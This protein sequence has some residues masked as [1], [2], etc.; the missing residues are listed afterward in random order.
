[1]KRLLLGSLLSCLVVGQISCYPDIWDCVRGKYREMVQYFFKPKDSKAFHSG[2]VEGVK[3]ASLGGA[4]SCVA[5]GVYA[6]EMEH[7][8]VFNITRRN[9]RLAVGALAAGSLYKGYLMSQVDRNGQ[10]HRYFDYYYD[11]SEVPTSLGQD[12]LN[13]T[14]DNGSGRMVAGGLTLAGLALTARRPAA[15]TA[16]LQQMRSWFSR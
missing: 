1:M 6:L 3:Q 7:P 16:K 11:G 2:M 5:T 13:K 12:G 10:H 4:V 14:A 9:T 15:L 8:S